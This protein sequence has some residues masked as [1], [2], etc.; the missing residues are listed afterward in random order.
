[1]SEII[2]V[3]GKPYTMKVTLGVLERLEEQRG[4]SVFAMIG[5]ETALRAELGKIKTLCC[6]A[7]E[8]LQPANA[9]FT[10]K[11]SYAEFMAEHQ[12]FK[13]FVKLSEC[14]GKALSDFFPKA[15]QEEAPGK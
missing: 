6:L 9:E 11:C 4:I 3:G 2:T 7:Y 15:E 8:A 13:A 5:D 1:M 12:D 14:V 10:K